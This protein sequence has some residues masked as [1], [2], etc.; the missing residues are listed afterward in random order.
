MTP[1]IALILA[2]DGIATGAIYVLIALGTVLI[3]SVTRVIFVP[4]GDIAAFSALTLA[5]LQMG[6]LPGTAYLV[7]VLAMIALAVEL[8]ALVR[9]RELDRWPRALL[10]YGFAPCL[11]ALVAWSVAGIRLPAGLDMMLALALVM[12]IAPLL[13]RIA[14]RPMADASTL[15]LLIVSVAVHFAISGLALLFFGPEGF[16]TAPLLRYNFELAGIPVSAQTLLMVAAAAAFSGLLYLYFEFTTEGRALRATAVN[17][18]GA[19]LV[20]IRPAQAA[21]RAYLLASVLG[22]VSGLLIGPVATLYYDSGF[23]I[24]LKAFIGAIIGGLVSY[25]LTAIGSIGIGLLETFASFFSSNLKEVIVF[26][27]LVPILIWRSFQA[28]HPNEEEDEEEKE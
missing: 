4:F 22:G 7:C 15:M 13:N 3:Y 10:W 5:S 11:P 9:D 23:V 28:G 19:R 21:T 26:S 17:H 27:A 20:G 12:P 18:T 14:F 16:R 1:D 8:F 25:P 6:R 2:V 24:G